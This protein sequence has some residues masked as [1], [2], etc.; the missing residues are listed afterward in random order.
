MESFESISH[1]FYYSST[2][3]PTLPYMGKEGADIK[4]GMWRLAAASLPFT[5]KGRSQ[6]LGGYHPYLIARFQASP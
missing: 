2:M 6:C 3:G 5:Q 1:D 4:E